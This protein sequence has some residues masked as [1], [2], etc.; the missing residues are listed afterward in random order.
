MNL[1]NPKSENFFSAT[2]FGLN[3]IFP[4]NFIKIGQIIPIKQGLFRFP[5]NLNQDFLANNRPL[6]MM[7]VTRKNHQIWTAVP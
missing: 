5:E 2:I 3:G 7:K 1:K 6:T 4:E